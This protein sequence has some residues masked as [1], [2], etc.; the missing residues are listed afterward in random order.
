MTPRIIA[1]LI[2][3]VAIPAAAQTPAP[4]VDSRPAAQVQVK[5]DKDK[6]K[7]VTPATARERAKAAK[8]QKKKSRQA[9]PQKPAE[10]QKKAPTG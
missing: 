3:A 4:P 9:V 10:S 8:A 6:A 2:A 7:A 1:A 5:Q